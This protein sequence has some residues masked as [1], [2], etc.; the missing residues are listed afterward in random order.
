MLKG[1]DPGT[2]Q[3]THQ[4]C[5]VYTC[6]TYPALPLRCLCLRNPQDA[7]SCTHIAHPAQCSGLFAAGSQHYS[8]GLRAEDT[9]KFV[10]PQ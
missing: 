3:A 4:V 6:G 1:L 8:T 7:L 10:K 2:S 9:A 5:H